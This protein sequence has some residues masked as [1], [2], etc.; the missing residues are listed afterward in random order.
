MSFAT[1]EVRRK[2]APRRVT[3]LLRGAGEIVSGL[4]PT[5]QIDHGCDLGQR[6]V[7]LPGMLVL[8]GEELVVGRRGRP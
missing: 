8:V 6:P 2:R 4:G 3:P 5:E 7:V 1:D